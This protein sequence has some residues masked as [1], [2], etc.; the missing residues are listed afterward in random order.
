[1]KESDASETLPAWS[2]HEPTTA[3]VALSGPLYRLAEEHDATPEVASVPE[4]E[5]V[6]GRLYQPFASGARSADAPTD[7]PVLSSLIFRVTVVVPP[8]LAAEQVKSVPGVSAVSVFESQPVV[9]RMIDSGSTIDQLRV[10][11]P[12]NQPVAGSDGE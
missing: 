4:K 12:R 8:S 11:V 6:S 9:E 10:T 3:I 2:V 5:T 7:G 1:L